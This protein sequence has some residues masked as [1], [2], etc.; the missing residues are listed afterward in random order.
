LQDINQPKRK[1]EKM[2]NQK[3]IDL[4]DQYTHELLDRREFLRRLAIVAGSTAAASG[5]LQLLE[6]NDAKAQIV[7]KDDPSLQTEYVKY[8]GATGDVRAYLA[9]PKGDE[10]LPGVVVIQEIGGLVPHIEDV[11][12]RVALEGFLAMAPDALSPLG[13]TPEDPSKAR[14]L[15]GKLDSQSTVQNY[16]AAVK[17]LK[18][19]PAS[20]GKVG[21]IGFCWGGGMAN[22]VAVN[23]P[24]VIAV[25]PYYGPQPAS[26]DVPKIKASLLLHYA[27]LDERIDKGIP[28]FE[29][30]LKKAS[31]DYRIYMYEGA[32]HAFNND[33]WADRYNKEAAQLAWQRTILFLK[34]KL[35]P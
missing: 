12:R 8:P 30:A 35:K 5:L 32:K 26:E 7:P 31:I 22:Q 16:V 20:T 4:Y 29:D 11:T 13:G 21:V 9:R 10:K 33:T 28:A 14:D 17:Y 6:N 1:G 27:G 18:T 25:V 24:D 19:H 34:E 3:I 23:S 15:M 2:M